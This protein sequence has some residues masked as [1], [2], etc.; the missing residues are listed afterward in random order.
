MSKEKSD[1]EEATPK[2]IEKRK[3]DAEDNKEMAK[4]IKGSD[5]DESDLPSIFRNTKF[6]ISAKVAK[7][8]KLKKYILA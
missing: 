7:L 8:Q 4:R 5:D 2:K 1:V 3:I 6:Y